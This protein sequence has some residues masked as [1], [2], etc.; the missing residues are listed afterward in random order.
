ML[1]RFLKRKKGFTLV[2]L[3][4]VVA[5]IGI[6]AGIAIPNFMGARTKA[7]VARAFADMDAIA[8]AEQMYY[9]DHPNEGYTKAASSDLVPVYIR[10]WPSEP[11]GND[12]RIGVTP[13][14]VDVNVAY[15]ILDNGPDGREDVNFSGT[16]SEWDWDAAVNG[17]I[18]GSEGA[19]SAYGVTISGA[20]GWYSPANGAKSAGDI[21]YGGG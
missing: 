9:M 21:G 11:W 19:L 6:L 20:K 3:L 7:Q 10:T 12:Y 5:I 2:E 14:T 16:P 18:G 13:D 8:K 4:I 15:A 17:A 1:K